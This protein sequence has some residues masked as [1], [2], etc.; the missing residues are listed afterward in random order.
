MN[1]LSM[2]EPLPAQW[3]DKHGGSWLCPRCRTMLGNIVVGKFYPDLA[4]RFDG[5]IVV[6]ES[7][8]D[9]TSPYDFCEIMKTKQ[10][11]ARAWSTTEERKKYRACNRVVDSTRPEIEESFGA[12]IGIIARRMISDNENTPGTY[13]SASQSFNLGSM[14]KLLVVHC[15]ACRHRAKITSRRGLE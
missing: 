7:K 9:G 2:N 12:E 6:D 15:P 10:G 5:Y 11:R 14:P 13:R 4:L 3:S 1:G 8:L